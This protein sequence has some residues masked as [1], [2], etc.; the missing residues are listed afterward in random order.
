MKKINLGHAFDCLKS[1]NF[2][3]SPMA[4]HRIQDALCGLQG[5][6]NFLKN[7]IRETAAKNIDGAI[8]L[9]LEGYTDNREMMEGTIGKELMEEILTFV[10][11]RADCFPSNQP[12]NDIPADMFRQPGLWGYLGDN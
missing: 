5:N 6:D 1:G 2:P 11:N 8:K 7:V 3:G 12:E 10:K 9:V 4:I